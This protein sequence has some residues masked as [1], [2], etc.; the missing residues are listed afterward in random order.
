MKTYQSIY[1]LKKEAGKAKE[2]TLHRH[3]H[4]LMSIPYTY[5]EKQVSKPNARPEKRE[6]STGVVPEQELGSDYSTGSET[7]RYIPPH[8]RPASKPRVLRPMQ[9]T[10]YT[11]VVCEDQL[12]S[13]GGEMSSIS[14]FRK[15][16][17]F[18]KFTF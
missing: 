8:R 6:Q 3:F 4:P 7:P 2:K 10:N 16:T 9:P 15:S 12:S 1:K 5:D 14:E 17:C 11:H 13:T 18:S